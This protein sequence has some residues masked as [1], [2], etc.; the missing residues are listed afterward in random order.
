MFNYFMI[1]KNIIQILDNLKKNLT[2]K[3]KD[4]KYK[5]YY[6]IAFFANLLNISIKN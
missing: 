4:N 1:K 5:L 6:I 3:F 2:F